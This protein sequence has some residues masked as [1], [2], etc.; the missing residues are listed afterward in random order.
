M[1]PVARVSLDLADSR[2]F[3]ELS[4]DF[5]P[6]HLDPIYARRMIFGNAVPHGMHLLLLALD[7]A[8]RESSSSRRLEALKAT[9]ALPAIHREPIEIQAEDDAAALRLVVRQN[10]MLL[11]TATLQFGGI[12]E[13][14]DHK[15]ESGRFAPET[16]DDLSLD[17]AAAACG[18]L[19]LCLDLNLAREMFPALVRTLPL[20]QIAILLA[21]TRLVGM[22]CPGMHSIFA[23]L[24][25]N[26][27]GAG[28]TT[29]EYAVHRTKPRL[30]LLGIG[31]RAEGT[32]GH[33]T[34]LMRPQATAQPSAA[35]LR[36]LVQTG[37]FSGQRVLVIGGSRGLGEIAAKI[38]ALGGAEVWLTYAHGADDAAAVVADIQEH[39]GKANAFQLDITNLPERVP[40]LGVPVGYRPTHVYLFATPPIRLVRGRGWDANLFAS[41]CRFYVDGV[42]ALIERVDS[43]AGAIEP[44]RLFY[45]STTFIERPPPGAAEY[46]A[47]KAAGEALCKSLAASR[48]SLSIRCPRLPPLRT[49]QTSSLVA[50]A[51]KPADPVPILLAELR[52]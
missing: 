50:V 22:K 2:C 24:E 16:A 47:A 48:P 27:A 18:T 7:R 21:T 20:W 46:I 15:P 43:V 10:H 13:Q 42:A 34:A 37:E 39:G 28:A 9:F 49:D 38:L 31:I 23:A 44:M 12:P 3:A 41:Y 26:F 5:N 19:A 35:D 4:G 51:G 33:I 6:L 52:A 40:L 30:N 45:P 17:E 11:Q 25:L 29:M 36:P 32:T 14:P 8:L 1:S